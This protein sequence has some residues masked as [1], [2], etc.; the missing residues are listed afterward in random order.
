MVGDDRAAL[1]LEGAEVVVA[2]TVQTDDGGFAVSG[3][4]GCDGF[5]PDVLPGPP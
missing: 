5:E 4:T 1:R 2:Y 3:S